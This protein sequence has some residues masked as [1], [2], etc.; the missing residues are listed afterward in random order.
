VTRKSDFLF[1]CQGQLIDI[2]ILWQSSTRNFYFQS[3]YRSLL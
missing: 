2:V 1:S 3:G